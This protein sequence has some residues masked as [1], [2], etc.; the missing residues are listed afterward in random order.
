M[1]LYVCCVQ[2]LRARGNE[3]EALTQR[4]VV[5]NDGL[6]KSSMSLNSMANERHFKPQCFQLIK[7]TQVVGLQII[8]CS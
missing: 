7:I 8:K 4:N 1:A 5:L 2:D 3:G 6:A